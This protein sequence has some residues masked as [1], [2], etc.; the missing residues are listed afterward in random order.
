MPKYHYKAKNMAGNTIEGVY[1]AQTKDA[2]INM[3]RQKYYYPLEVKELIERKDINEL[4]IFG[5]IKANELSIYCKQF[6][7][8]LR[9]GVPLI[10]CL[11]LLGEQT[12][13][14]ILKS[15]TLKVR[16]DVQ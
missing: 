12:D 13:N 10:H 1:E 11:G 2:V 3:I 5:R 8:I 16:E 6:C 15:I 7:S 4:G 14:P 9:A